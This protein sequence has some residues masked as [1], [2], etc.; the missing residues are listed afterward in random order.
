MSEEMKRKISDNRKGKGI[1]NTNCKGKIPW[2]KG[3]K[4][5]KTWNSGL[6]VK[7]LGYT[8]W[9]DKDGFNG[10]SEEHI[11]KL[12]ES[13]IGQKAWNKDKKGLQTA[14]NKGL[15][16]KELGYTH[17]T[18]KEDFKGYSDEAKMNMSKS[19]IGIQS[20]KK[21]K[22]S[23]ICKDK[24]PMW[25]G[26]IAPLNIQIRTLLEMKQW[27]RQVLMR[28]YFTCQY[29][30]CKSK[31]L[32]AHHIFHLSWILEAL[33]ITEAEQILLFPFMFDITNGI[34]VCQSCHKYIHKYQNV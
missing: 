1:G 6:K 30:H 10:F 11:R 16:I 33:N 26:G 4:T 32:S 19:H 27:S 29:C 21:G 15:K 12:K 14:W 28:D 5:G 9:T 7:E 13:H 31:K 25:K 22:K 18:S 34:T 2:N 23:N 8:H 24:H 17:W 20:P 3:K